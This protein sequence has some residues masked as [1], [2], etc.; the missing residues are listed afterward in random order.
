MRPAEDCP[1]KGYKVGVVRLED[2]GISTDEVVEGGVVVAKVI[3]G[4]VMGEGIVFEVEV[5][6]DETW[7]MIDEVFCFCVRNT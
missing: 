1:V 3:D 4:V 7:W 6:I 5:P 2:H